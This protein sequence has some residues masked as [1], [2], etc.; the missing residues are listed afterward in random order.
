MEE[1]TVYSKITVILTKKSNTPLLALT[2]PA[3][4]EI[5]VLENLGFDVRIKGK[6]SGDTKGKYFAG[7][8]YVQIYGKDFIRVI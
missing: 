7:L 4:M 2:P 8:R 3:L 5:A 6:L 1:V